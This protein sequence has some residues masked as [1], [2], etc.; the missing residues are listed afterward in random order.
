MLPILESGQKIGD[1]SAGGEN[2]EAVED[3]DLHKSAEGF[4]GGL[5]QMQTMQLL[6]RTQSLICRRF[7]Q[8]MKKYK[9]PAYQ[10]ILSCLKLPKSCQ[11]ALANDDKEA[12]FASSLMTTKRAQFILDTVG[13]VFQTCLVSPLNAEELV[14][15]SGV[16]ILEDLLHFFLKIAQFTGEVTTV[17]ANFATDSTI[18]EILS[19]LLHTIAGVAFYE[20]GRAA[21]IALPDISRFCINWRRCLEGKYL[22]ARFKEVG[23]SQIKKFALEGVIN[24]AKDGALQSSLVGAGIVWPLTRFLLGFDPTLDEGNVSNDSLEDDLG[25][26]QAACNAQARLATRA[27]GMLCGVL[28]HSSLASPENPE[29]QKAMSCILTNPIAMLLRNKRST[30]LL[31]TLNSNMQTPSRIWSVSMRNELTKLLDRMGENRPEDE[32]QSVSK[33]LQGVDTF[34]YAE[35]KDELQIGGIYIRIFNQLGVEK[36]AMRHVQN[37]A[38]FVR[39]LAAFLGRC[40]NHSKDLPDGWTN[41]VINPADNS[42]S[43]TTDMESTYVPISDNRFVQVITAFRNLVRVDGIV[44]DVLSDV[45][46]SVGSVLLS[47]LELPQ[48]SEVSC[49]RFSICSEWH[50]SNIAFC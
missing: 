34:E 37:P 39:Q 11:S 50:P 17:K 44:D 2:F 8:E 40:I 25:V 30:E 12:M 43:E 15:E 10:I 5:S 41:I 38:L 21:L 4:V 46:M 48:D 16:V 45:S 26:S 18:C 42:R 20:S 7:E 47:L 13:L 49:I 19:T 35:L 22:G 3:E 33:E 31:S 9:Y 14:A 28:Q 24:M 32:L 23:D 6:F 36:G 1:L 29:L 27:L